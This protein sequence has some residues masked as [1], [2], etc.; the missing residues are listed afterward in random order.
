MA[1]I[2]SYKRKKEA[3]TEQDITDMIQERKI[4]RIERKYN[5]IDNIVE[6]AA[7]NLIKDPEVSDSPVDT[8][9]AVKFFSIAENK[10]N[11]DMQTLF[12]KI[13]SDEVKRPGSYSVRTINLINSIDKKMQ[14]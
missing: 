7:K 2:D 6:I 10:S 14:K 9:W 4:K 1:D 12:G 8:D 11:N 3:E 13:L 5:N